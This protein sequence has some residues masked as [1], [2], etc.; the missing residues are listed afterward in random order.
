M[1]PMGRFASYDGTRLA[2]RVLGTG[3]PLICVPGGPGLTPDYL[4]DLGG[5]AATRQLVLLVN[6]GTGE[7]GAAG[8]PVGY[9]ADRLAED[10]EALRVHLG[11]QQFDL[12][13]HSAAANP[14]IC[15]AARYPGRL[16]HLILL[17]PLLQAVG[18]GEQSP[19]E[20][21]E[22]L[23]RR[24]GEPWFGEAYAAAQAWDAG[25]DTDEN[26]RKAGA[27]FYG[28]W[29]EAAAAHWEHEVRLERAATAA[30]PAFYADGAFDPAATRAALARLDVPVLVYAGGVDFGPA[31]Q[32]AAEAASLFPRGKLIVQPG[33]GHMPWLDDPAFFAGAITG[34][35]G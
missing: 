13:G 26:R 28:R 34:F 25:A 9:R 7:S 20:W 35:L 11:L 3:A 33:A 15:Y 14:V 5:L 12:L 17:T 16:A 30:G 24:S 4:R 8:D 23:R 1:S 29:D 21:S 22:A 2:Y 31:P 18:I 19:Q 10:I 6:R 32:Q 27:F